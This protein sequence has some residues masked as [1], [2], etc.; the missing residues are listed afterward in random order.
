MLR[1]SAQAT[2]TTVELA[3][4]VDVTGDG[5]VPWGALLKAFVDAALSEDDVRLADVRKQLRDTLGDEALVDTA[6]V[7][8]NYAAL[9]R[10]ADATGIPLEPAKEANTATFRAELGIDAFKRVKG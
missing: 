7:I 6:A 2:E 3:A 4:I 10:V 9:D 1:A 8:A 5:G